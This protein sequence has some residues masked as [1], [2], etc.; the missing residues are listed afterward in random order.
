MNISGEMLEAYHYCVVYNYV[1]SLASLLEAY[2][3]RY[4]DDNSILKL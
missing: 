1:S 2:N 4:P 3:V